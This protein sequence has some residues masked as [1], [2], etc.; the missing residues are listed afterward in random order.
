MKVFTRRNALVGWLVVRT[1]RRKA[2]RRLDAVVGRRPERR[3]LALGAGAVTVAGVGAVLGRR[4]RAA[5]SEP[6]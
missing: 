6:A 1:A 4:A 2:R 5:A 3:R